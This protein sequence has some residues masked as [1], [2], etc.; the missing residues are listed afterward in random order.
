MTR[1]GGY[2]IVLWP[3]R[4]HIISPNVVLLDVLCLRKI[5]PRESLRVSVLLSVFV[6]VISLNFE[7]L[8]VDISCNLGRVDRSNY[9]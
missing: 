3:S 9:I 8:N 5:L 7:I 1:G 6:P 4:G 2:E